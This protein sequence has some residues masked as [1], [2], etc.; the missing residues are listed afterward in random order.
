MTETL[1]KLTQEVKEKMSEILS[2]DESK[3][4]IASTKAAEDSGTFEVVISTSDVDRQGESIDQAG[5]DLTNYKNNPVVLWGHDYYSLPIGICESVELVNGRLVAKGRFAPEAANPFAQQVRKLYDAGIIRA[6]SVGFIVHEMEG[7]IITKSELLEFSFVPVPANPYALSLSQA[8]ELDLVML[9][10]KGLK[11]EVKQTDEDEL[12]LPPEDPKVDPPEDDTTEKAPQM[13]DQCDLG[14]GEMGTMQD[15]GN[16]GIV[17]KPK[18]VQQEEGKSL[19]V[20]AEKKD[21]QQIGAVLAQLQNF[22]DSAIIEASKIIL[23]IYNSEYGQ[24]VAGKEAIAEVLKTNPFFENTKKAF[25]SFEQKLGIDEGEEQL[26]D[27]APNQR[28]KDTEA[29]LA[30]LEQW[31]ASKQLLKSIVTA[32]SGALGTINR[33]ER[34]ARGKK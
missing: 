11:L 19:F 31:A 32:A 17:C 1:K 14:D 23:D 12:T 20:L 33:V 7:H 16:G 9:A 26:G 24:S 5:I 18:A 4:L 22:V 8:K 34:E 21:A 13:G 3:E 27:A 2:S 25:V 29:L 28:S 6:T 10:T 30:T 15:D